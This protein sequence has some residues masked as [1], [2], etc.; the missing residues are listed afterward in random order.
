MGKL[1]KFQM[2]TIFF[3]PKPISLLFNGIK[4]KEVKAQRKIRKIPA[5]AFM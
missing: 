5:K 1:P 2:I 4:E 3:L